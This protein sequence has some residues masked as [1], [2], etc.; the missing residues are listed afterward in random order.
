MAFVQPARRF[1]AVVPNLPVVTDP[2]KELSSLRT[3]KLLK[4]TLSGNSQNYTQYMNFSV[5]IKYFNLIKLKISSNKKL[6]M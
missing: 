1:N 2:F 4:V 3:P 6:H 5:Q